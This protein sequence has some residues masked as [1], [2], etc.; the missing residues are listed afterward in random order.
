MTMW[1]VYRQFNM[2]SKG[3]G[4]GSADHR[5]GT[6]D[7]PPAGSR[8]S[9]GCGSAVHRPDTSDRPPVESRA[10]KLVRRRV[11]IKNNKTPRPTKLKRKNKDTA[12]A[13][14]K[15]AKA[16]ESKVSRRQHF[17]SVIEKEPGESDEIWHARKERNE[18]LC[19]QYCPI[20]NVV[21][22]HCCHTVMQDR[23]ETY[24]EYEERSERICKQ[25]CPI[26]D[27]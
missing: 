7:K 10:R 19:E 2:A 9:K 3:E 22:G 24:D 15:S 12:T 4:R 5:S 20:R 8:A 11:K 21:E 23:D 26:W 14:A 27:K 16:D 13:P 6:C 25:Y 17:C 18:E 1:F